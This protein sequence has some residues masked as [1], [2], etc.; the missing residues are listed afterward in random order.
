MKVLFENERFVVKL[1]EFQSKFVIF[2]SEL[3]FDKIR[4]S[5]YWNIRPKYTKSFNTE[6]SASRYA[7]RF[8][9]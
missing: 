7:E 1:M 3:N 8:K 9:Q 2:V 4:Q 5:S 6:D